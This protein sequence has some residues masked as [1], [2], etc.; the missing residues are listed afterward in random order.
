[1]NWVTIKGMHL[2]LDHVQEFHWKD[3]EL[4]IALSGDSA[5]YCL[6]DP[7]RR[8]YHK[9]CSRVSLPPVEKEAE[10]HV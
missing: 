9:L 6:N 10:S 1:M 2:N 4:R 5:F 3:G 7:D 8:W